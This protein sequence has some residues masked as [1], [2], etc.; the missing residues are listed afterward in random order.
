MPGSSSQLISNTTLHKTFL[1]FII[2]FKGKHEPNKL[3]CVCLHSSVG[4]ST[5][6]A[7]QIQIPLNHLG[8]FQVCRRQLLKVCSECEHHL[9]IWFL[10]PHFTKHFFHW[11]I[12]LCMQLKN[13]WLQW[14][15]N[16]WPLRCHCS[17]LTN[18]AYALSWKQ[19]NLI[20]EITWRKDPR[21]CW[22]I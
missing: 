15:S 6:P 22:T 13:R 16:P 1:S 7:S 18:W 3:T 12:V 17:A 10:T 11:A 5:A 21:T 8:G 4:G 20:L 19:V 9:F 2:P 14:D